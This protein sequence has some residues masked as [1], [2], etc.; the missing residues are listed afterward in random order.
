MT[1]PK[2]IHPDSGRGWWEELTRE[3]STMMSRKE[4]YARATIPSTLPDK[5]YNVLNDQLSNGATSLGNQGATN[6][7]NKLMLA[8]FAPG[9]S[10]FKLEMVA[11]AKAE[12][13][14]QMQM[15]D[16]SLLTDVLAE[17]E[18]EAG[19]AFEQSGSRPAL[20]EGLAGL[21]CVGD[22]LMDLSDTAAISFITLHDYA[23]KRNRKGKVLRLIFR[24]K[25][26]VDDLEKEAQ[27]EY[28]KAMPMA[29]MHDKVTIYTCIKLVS[30]MYRST[31][32][33]D[34]VKLSIRHSG[35]WKEDTLP[36]RALTW[37]LPIGQDYGV[38]LAE[39]Y[40]NDLATHDMVSESMADGGVLASQFRWA[41]NPTG[42]TQ[43][44]DVENSRNGSVIAANSNDLELIFA[45]MGQQ[46]QTVIAV[47]EVYARRIGRGFLL[48]TAV[49]RNA[50]RVTVEEVRMQAQELETS[51]GGVYS[52]MSMDMQGP[53]SRWT[54]RKADISIQGTKI[55]PTIITGLDALSRTAEQQRLMGFLQ[56]VL[57]LSNIP[58][59]TRI[60]LNEQPIISDM[61]AGRGVDRRKYVA[62]PETVARRRQEQ[63]QAQANA[64]A[65]EAGIQAGAQQMVNEDQAQ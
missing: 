26:R 20:Y 15:Q 13:L 42:V 56:D 50:E 65:T 62:D 31:V 48:N 46:L 16:D 12:F 38:S 27:S 54:L 1:D 6:V 61:A 5:N 4:A 44:E 10:F 39:D 22:V 55:E 3:R 2:A 17:G 24:E 47:E 18:R 19:R 9:L 29:K 25:T 52:R 51:F 21:V 40:A 7:V 30:G 28:R 53:I 57:N 8:L 32:W 49:T 11:K 59:E 64:Q 14:Q 63:A 45:N 36:W 35:K 33:V 37:R 34:D 58:P 23:V 41:C 60:M 43:P